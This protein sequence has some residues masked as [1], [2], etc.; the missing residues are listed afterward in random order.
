MVPLK[1][2]RC[3]LL[4]HD[5][6][7]SS[8]ALGR[9]PSTSRSHVGNSKRAPANLRWHCC[10][11]LIDASIVSCV[12]FSTRIACDFWMLFGHGVCPTSPVSGWV[13]S[14]ST[15]E[16]QA[17][18]VQ[19]KVGHHLRESGRVRDIH[20]Q[21]RPKHAR[22]LSSW[23]VSNASPSSGRRLPMMKLARAR[24][25]IFDQR[26]SLQ[27]HGVLRCL[28]LQLG[29]HEFNLTHRSTQDHQT[30]FTSRQVGHLSTQL[31]WGRP[32]WLPRSVLRMRQGTFLHGSTL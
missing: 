31:L 12:R 24:L 3:L 5:P 23:P 1:L 17:S 21:K 28:L 2:L 16:T 11:L 19:W 20:I 8:E 32:T 27:Q 4:H 13:E 22:T 10:T 14:H 15:A 26:D 9:C 6:S 18:H 29:L 30:L 25:E 7:S